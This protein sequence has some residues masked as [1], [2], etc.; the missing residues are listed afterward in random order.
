[1]CASVSRAAQVRCHASDESLLRPGSHCPA[2]ELAF[3]RPG[4]ADGR[5][6]GRT[7]SASKIVFP[8]FRTII[9]LSGAVRL[10][11]ERAEGCAGCSVI[12]R[13]GLFGCALVL[14]AHHHSSERIFAWRQLSSLTG[15]NHA[16]FLLSGILVLVFVSVRFAE[17][18]QCRTAYSSLWSHVTSAARFVQLRSSLRSVVRCDTSWL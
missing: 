14:D 7:S 12:S 3:R 4:E 13:L 5:T 1:M 6:D 16:L 8:S 11:E 18:P 15:A 10:G 9:I 17:R 2:A